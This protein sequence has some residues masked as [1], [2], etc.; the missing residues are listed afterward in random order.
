MSTDTPAD[1]AHDLLPASASAR[2]SVPS[3]PARGADLRL[4]ISAPETGTSLPVVVFS[5][6]FGSSADGYDPL[7]GAWVASGLAVVQPTHLDSPEMGLAPDDPRGP[8]FWRSRI[9]DLRNA[10]DQLDLIEAAVPG[11]SGRIDR[12]R[13]AV[14]GHSW[15]GQTASTLLGARVLGPD[16]QPGEDLSDPR[17]RAGVLLSTA[18]TG[19]ADLSPFAADNFPFMNPDFDS[20]TTP[21]LVVAGD[22]DD[23]PLTTRG[24]DWFTDVYA[25][26]PGADHLITL[27]GAEHGL[28]GIVG[29]GTEA[30][31][32]D[33]VA[34]VQRLTAAYLASALTPDD[35]SWRAAAADVGSD[36]DAVGRIDSKTSSGSA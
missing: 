22:A 31:D 2:L 5:H 30:P 3:D 21:T 11:L 9:E 10:L 23:S 15:G 32:E 1:T 14:A 24:P 29:D 28:G 17:V 27:F 18:G 36:T 35:G 33:R 19:G 20:L 16:G 34:F 13:V 26:S 12:G 25:L 4:R 6:G 8:G 7:V